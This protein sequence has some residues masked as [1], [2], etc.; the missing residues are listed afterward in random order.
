MLAC[1]IAGAAL[2]ACADDVIGIRL[3]VGY[4][5]T[6]NFELKDHSNGHLEGPE[7][8]ADFPLAK[9]PGIQLYVT[10]SVMFGGK[11]THG[12]DVDGTIYRFMLTAHQALTKDGF[13]G[14]V[15]AGVAHSETRGLN[16]F[17]DQ[18]GFV[19]ALTLGTPLK[20]KVLGITPSIEGSYYF[21][22]RDQFR[23]F[24]I[25]IAASF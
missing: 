3:K 1:S 16:E 22:S 24:T 23:G 18:N 4:H 8:A 14:A 15:S 9:Y 17:K 21:S 13:Y 25:G 6:Q 2:T 10:P 5:V 20:F 12:S 19:T 11:L 7:V